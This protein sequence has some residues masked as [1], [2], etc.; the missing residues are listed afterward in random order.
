MPESSEPA[1][2]I[3]ELHFA[4][5]V[6]VQ[7]IGKAP[8]EPLVKFTAIAKS[9]LVQTAKSDLLA[10][11]AALSLDLEQPTKRAPIIIS[12]SVFIHSMSVYK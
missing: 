8:I 6:K 7:T 1:I 4:P 11:G 2:V 5:L 3:V 12:D 10:A 9:D